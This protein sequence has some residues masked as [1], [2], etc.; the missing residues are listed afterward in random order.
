[1]SDPHITP[2]S[3]AFQQQPKIDAAAQAH[4][5]E[6]ATHGD[7]SLAAKG[8]TATAAAAGSDRVRVEWIYPSEVA[9][10][11]A[12]RG[13]SVGADIALRA[14]EW[15]RQRGR[16]GAETVDRPADAPPPTRPSGRRTPM[17]D[18]PGRG[19]SV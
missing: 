7:P 11:L 16:Q 2:R 9:S 8:G 12:A 15:L 3:A 10:R 18:D 19:L 4:A 14:R 6:F 5:S 17:R 1:M 13:M